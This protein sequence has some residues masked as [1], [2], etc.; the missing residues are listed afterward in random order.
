MSHLPHFQPVV[1][2]PHLASLIPPLLHRP[3]V[4]PVAPAPLPVVMQLPKPLKQGR[5]E[6]HNEGEGLKERNRIAA[7]KWRCRKDR[8]MTELET[9]NDGLRKQAL[10]LCLEAK[11]VLVENKLLEDELVF[12]QKFMS[13]IMA[14]K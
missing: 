9:E 4:E 8:Y 5:R 12:F 1:M 6:K 11:S 10:D 14:P 3:A 7:Q 2:P 13:L